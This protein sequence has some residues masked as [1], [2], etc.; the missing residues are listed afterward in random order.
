MDHGYIDKNKHLWFQLVLLRHFGSF[1]LLDPFCSQYNHVFSRPRTRVALA[2]GQGDHFDGLFCLRWAECQGPVAMDWWLFFCFGF[3][4]GFIGYW[5]ERLKICALRIPQVTVSWRWNWTA[6]YAYG[7]HVPKDHGPLNSGMIGTLRATNEWPLS[8]PN[9]K[10]CWGIKTTKYISEPVPSNRSFL[11]NTSWKSTEM[12]H[13]R[14][15][16]DAW[17]TSHGNWRPMSW[18]RCEWV[19]VIFQ[20][21][22]LSHNE[23]CVWNG[24]CLVVWPGNPSNVGGVLLSWSWEMRC[25]F[26]MCHWTWS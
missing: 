5:I 22:N 19:T 11:T 18:F 23:G 24:R 3:I 16:L 13:R 7:C 4:G 20:G 9:C 12:F 14:K 17:E 6:E 25:V 8:H 10:I 1:K 2:G 15:P 21:F 26:V